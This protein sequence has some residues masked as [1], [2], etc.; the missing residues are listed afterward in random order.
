MS[1]KDVIDSYYFEFRLRYAG[2]YYG[3]QRAIVR[4]NQ[5]P[6]GLGRIKVQCPVLFGGATTSW[7][8]PAATFGGNSADAPQGAVF[9][10][11]VGDMVWIELEDGNTQKPP[12][13]SGG[14]WSR[15]SVPDHARAFPDDADNNSVKGLPGG[16]IPEST[17]SATKIGAIRVLQLPS[18]SRL[19]F[20]ETSGTERVQLY[21]K[22]GSHIEI[23]QDGTINIGA[24]QLVRIQ[25]G[26]V[27][28][29][30]A[31]GGWQHTST[32]DAWVDTGGWSQSVDNGGEG[33]HGLYKVTGIGAHIITCDTS[34]FTTAGTVTNKIGGELVE[35]VMGKET[36]TIANQASMMVGTDWFVQAAG[37][38]SLVAQNSVTNGG[39]PTDL[40]A[41]L[42][43]M[44]SRAIVQ[45]TDPTGV[46]TVA[47]LELNGTP[48][49]ATLS[50][51][52]VNLLRA[53]QLWVGP[54]VSELGV[55][56]TRP[57]VYADTLIALI[58]TILTAFDTHFHVS[59]APGTPTTTPTVPQTPII[60]P[61][62]A[63]VA[64]PFV[65]QQ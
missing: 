16:V 52:L 41:E 63:A 55:P 1:L 35:T 44:N 34:D 47:K 14:M 56:P 8:W 50:A 48:G 28:E 27:M 65:L 25:S 12:L 31:A 29:T 24:A 61:T 45:S 20:D 32:G 64:N 26:S 36:R 13:W 17:F 59:G 58:G 49:N 3:K 53:P 19:E 42:T 15:E 18:G 6:S 23:M 30:H 40:G 46:A 22:S 21:H 43:A 39:L 2:R 33:D 54:T 38:I 57:A 37:G 5:D 51:T 10:P 7:C 60:G 62:V 9:I 4:D 11:E